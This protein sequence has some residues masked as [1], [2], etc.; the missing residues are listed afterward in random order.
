MWRDS[1]L[2]QSLLSIIL[3][4]DNIIMI[5][6]KQQQQQQQQQQSRFPVHWG[7]PPQ[8]QTR[9]LRQLPGDYGKGSGT[10]AK[11]ITMKMAEDGEE[12]PIIVGGAK[13]FLCGGTQQTPIDHKIVKDVRATVEKLCD[14]SFSAF[15]AT[16]AL[17]QA[18]AGTMWYYHVNT[19]DNNHLAIKVMQELPHRG[20]G[21]IVL[22]VKQGEA[23][24]AYFENTC[25]EPVPQATQDDALS[26]SR[27]NELVGKDGE[28]AK[29]MVMRVPGV[30]VAGVVS[31]GS[32]MTMDH[33]M[34]RV[35]IFVDG[36]GKVSRQP[37]RG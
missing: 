32:M 30:K 1:C 28:A 10:L 15:D 23:E 37:H 25:N 26:E 27:W 13:P 21:L 8:I 14:R 17:T 11:W 2:Y 20:G 19:G 33:R 24:L 16:A 3:Q 12:K 31:E 5:N 4:L 22:G 6:T 29:E 36:N 34:D 7:E 35:R 18:V 9:D